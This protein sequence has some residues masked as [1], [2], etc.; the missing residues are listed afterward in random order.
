[1]AW[2]GVLHLVYGTGSG[3]MRAR[4]CPCSRFVPLCVITNIP[5]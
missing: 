5:G 4:R 1:M 2:E 3:F